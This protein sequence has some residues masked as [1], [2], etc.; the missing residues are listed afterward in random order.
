MKRFFLEICVESLPSALAAQR[1]GANRV[2]LCAQ[3]DIGGL[4]PAEWLTS[5]VIDA[6]AIPVHVLIRSRG[7]D[8]MFTPGELELM[9]RQIRWVKRAG[10]AG[11]VVGVAHADGRIDVNRSR[12][13]VELARPMQVTFHRAFD[14]TPEKFEALEAVIAT[15]ADCLLTSGGAADVLAGAATIARLARQAGQRIQI[16]AGGGLRLTNLVQ[17]LRRSEVSTLHGSLSR[18][19]MRPLSAN[20]AEALE[21]DVR[22][23]V[24]LLQS[25][26]G[27]LDT[28]AQGS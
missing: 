21:A 23:A 12:E 15:G 8:F 1:G 19:P 2:E 3:L 5:E 22:D 10:A 13:L 18:R 20:P 24:G 28:A 9:K 27:A 7:G 16:M 14:E 25:E 4:T 26:L 6:L 17:V 11:V